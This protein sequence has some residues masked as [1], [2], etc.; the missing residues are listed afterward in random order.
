MNVPQGA[1]VAFEVR[2]PS[3]AVSPVP[4]SAPEPP[5]RSN[6]PLQEFDNIVRASFSTSVRIITAILVW[7]LESTIAASLSNSGGTQLQVEL[8]SRAFVRKDAC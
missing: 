2:L 1:H 6:L 7:E 8:I 5:Y 4:D 3:A